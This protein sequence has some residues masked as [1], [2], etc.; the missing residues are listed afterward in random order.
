MRSGRILN[1]NRYGP[2]GGADEAEKAKKEE[3]RLD[4]TFLLDMPYMKRRTWLFQ[5]HKWELEQEKGE[6]EER[7]VEDGMRRREL[8]PGGGTKGRCKRAWRGTK[9]V[10]RR[11]IEEGG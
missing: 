3:I 2:F 8:K 1:L 6:P 7:V 9:T 11:K 5:L 4:S 10:R